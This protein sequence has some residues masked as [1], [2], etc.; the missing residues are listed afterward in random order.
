MDLRDDDLNLVYG[1]KT[2]EEKFLDNVILAGNI[3]DDSTNSNVKPSK[4]ITRDDIYQS[5]MNQAKEQ[6]KEIKYSDV[7]KKI[8]W[9]QEYKKQSIT[10]TPKKIRAYLRNYNDLDKLIEYRKEQLLKGNV[11]PV[12]K[13]LGVD[14]DTLKE[15]IEK[16]KLSKNEFAIGVD[17]KLQE[18]EFYKL[19][20][21]MMLGY[22]RY[23]EFMAFQFVV[24]RYFLKLNDAQINQ[25]TQFHNLQA[26]DNHTIDYLVSKLSE[27]AEKNANE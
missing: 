24:M 4:K 22:L 11:K 19:N 12:S 13:S 27:E 15:L 25:L 6:K 1:D 2:N 5:V 3:G 7:S 20:L 16:T 8:P 23:Y 26:M 14:K 9:F 17:Y 18:M 21:T 10:V